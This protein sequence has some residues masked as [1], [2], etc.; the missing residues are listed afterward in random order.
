VLVRKAEQG[1]IQGTFEAAFSARVAMIAQRMAT[2]EQIL[3]GAAE[4]A[5]Q[6]AGLSRRAWRD[7]V[8]A[9]ELPR[10]YP[11][12]QGLGH[13]LW[14][15][16]GELPGHVRRIRSEGFPGYQVRALDGAASSPEG[17]GVVVYLEP[18][19][20]RNVRA[21]GLDV[22]SEPA[23]REA[24][25]RARDQGVVAVTR[26]VHLVQ[27]DLAERGAGV[28]LYAPI[29][30]KGMAVATVA[31]RRR[32]LLGW[33]NLPLRM[34]D[35][36]LGTLGAVPEGFQLHVA[37]VGNGAPVQ[38]FPSSPSLVSA[39]AQAWR[40]TR[41]TR[42]RTLD[43]AGRT[44]TIQAQADSRF[45][46]ARGEGTHWTFLVGGT[47]VSLLTCLALAVMARSEARAEGLAD[48]RLK[49]L[50]SS[51][52]RWKFAIEGAGDGLWD[53]DVASGRVYFSPRWKAMLGHGE[54]E[55]GETLLEWESRVHPEDLASVQAAVQRHLAGET[56]SYQSEHRLKC[57]DGTYKWILDRGMVVER[58]AEG[59]PVRV[60]G[61]HSDLTE[62][63]N[64]EAALRE[65][66]KAEGLGL[67]AAGISHDF[68]NLFQSLLGNLELAHLRSDPAGRR[69]IDRARQ[70]LDKAAGLSRRLLEF[71][72]GSFTHLGTLSVN[73]LV[74]RVVDDHAPKS[75]V[76]PRLDLDPLVPEV[77]A[78]PQQVRQ[79]LDILLEN[80]LEAVGT[81]GGN[82]TLS[83]E[84]LPG[85]P[86]PERT[87]GVWTGEL[88][89]GPLVRITIAD[90]GGGAG[91]E[92]MSRL[93]DPFFST[94]ALGR[95]LGLPSA[96]GL[97]RG[98][99]AGLQVV[100]RP[101][102]G[103]T[104]RIYLSAERREVRREGSQPCAPA[105]G[106]RAVLVV[107][108]EMELRQVLC[109]ALRDCHGCQVFE[110]ADGVEAIEVF[111]AHRDEIGLV[112]MDSVM[113]RMKGPEAFDEIRRIQPGIPGILISG[114]SEGKGQDLA[115]QHGFSAFLKKPFPLKHLT[116][117]MADIQASPRNASDPG[118]TYS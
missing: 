77:V 67:M 56:A 87:Q 68:N 6:Q 58:T 66:H 92:V 17:T 40:G 83:S 38:L 50:L 47:L 61:T 110:A 105:G 100:D 46:T 20:E 72:G 1:R 101:G 19:D 3:K 33:T 75:P 23:R 45:T 32:A 118:G 116:D 25:R 16:A 31:D 79:V 12:I 95:G 39:Q 70:S 81:H 60:I 55:I 117:L 62:R 109:E 9:L 76:R 57:K 107:D 111:Q 84:W 41:L 99:R 113:P 82:V 85:L 74:R 37:E 104:F 28:I 93:F 36:I 108:D 91:P 13:A 59:L 48:R 11:G 80:A 5:S 35:H 102:V 4:F 34:D 2:E 73:A 71:S 8:T 51:E 114:F 86:E 69:I 89:A 27:D 18:M 7:Y 88:P 42:V 78:D 10:R 26:P 43:V 65:A 98:N 15:P 115:H 63:R 44:W 24:L 97:L 90:T 14:V 29:Y 52:A 96:L 49:D 53:W 54:A 21:L 64:A 103:M 112:L 30:R 22:W 106:G 94:K